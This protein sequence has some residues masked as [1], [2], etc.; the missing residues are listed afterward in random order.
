M[1]LTVEVGTP[2]RK[3]RPAYLEQA[4][5]D[6]RS[7]LNEAQYEHAV[8]QVLLLCEEDDPTHPRLLDVD[9]LGEFHELRDKYGVLGKINLRV[10][11]W[12]SR[13]HKTV[14][15]L[16]AWKK[17]SEGQTPTRIIKRIKGVST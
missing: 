6:A 7:F 15:V 12:V 13:E 3:W 9:A 16:G 8:Q 17:E 5:A 10:F 2:S 4:S 1:E 11:F 14:V